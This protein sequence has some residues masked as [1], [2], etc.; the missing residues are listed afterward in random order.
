M[1][2][3]EAIAK[4]SD[5][6]SLKLGENKIDAKAAEALKSYIKDDQCRLKTLGLSHADVNDYELISFLRVL[7]HNQYLTSLD[8]SRNLIGQKYGQ[9]SGVPI[10]AEYLQTHGMPAE[11]S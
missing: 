7:E 4:R 1:P 10:L 8:L 5:V 6:Q 9:A 11:V 3:I 2:I